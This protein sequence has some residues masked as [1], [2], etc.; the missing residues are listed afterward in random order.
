MKLELLRERRTI[1]LIIG[2]LLLITAAVTLIVLPTLNPEN[3]KKGEIKEKVS[4]KIN[5]QDF[6]VDQVLV[7][8][9]GWTLGKISS[10][11]KD[12]EGNAAMVILHEENDIL[13]LKFGPG[14]SFFK[15]D[16]DTAGVPETIQDV[17]FGGQS[18]Y[19]EDPIIQYLPRE[20]NFYSV[21]YVPNPEEQS[22]DKKRL[23]ITIFEVPKLGIY[24]TPEKKAQYKTETEEWIR[25]L[26]LEPNNYIFIFST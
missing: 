2:I 24:A 6:N 26:G 25:S 14:T 20:T 11:N 19:I 4:E 16:L 15:A 17:L 5:R 22:S 9:N 18:K 8:S 23:R 12:D 1:V 7:E 21:K 10:T 13:V 3:I